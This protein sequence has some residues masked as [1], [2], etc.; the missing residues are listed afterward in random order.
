MPKLCTPLTEKQVAELEPKDARY[1]RGDG[2]GLCL[3]IEPTGVKL[4]RMSYKF[5]GT[6]TSMSFGPYPE[7]S[8]SAARQQRD[9]VHRLV[10]DGINPV[11]LKRAQ[12]KQNRIATKK[13][14]LR[15]FMSEDGGVIIETASKQMILSPAKVAALRAFLNVTDEAPKEDE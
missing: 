8:L 15:L 7:V 3:L 9:N 11:K 2:R 6:E 14:K 5:H 4:W 10:A 12:A 1:K 13:P